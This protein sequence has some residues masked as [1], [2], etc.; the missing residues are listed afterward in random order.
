MSR[1]PS[2]DPYGRLGKGAAPNEVMA[3]FAPSPTGGILDGTPH[4]SLPSGN[5][6]A[7][8][9]PPSLNGASRR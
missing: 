8:H 3:P 1:R 6:A 9:I 5:G 4:R 7:L 2:L